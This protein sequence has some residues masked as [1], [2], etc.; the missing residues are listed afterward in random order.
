MLGFPPGPARRHRRGIG[1]GSRSLIAI[2]PVRI[3]QPC[4]ACELTE[5]FTAFQTRLLKMTLSTGSLCARAAQWAAV[6]VPKM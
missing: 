2:V 5:R 6:G 4:G 3:A 1:A